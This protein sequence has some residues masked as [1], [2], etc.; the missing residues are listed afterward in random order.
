MSSMELE[1]SYNTKG[2]LQVKMWGAG[3]K[4]HN[5]TTTEKSTG[6]EQINKSLPKEIRA[7]LGESKYEIERE[8]WEKK[9][10]YKKQMD[11]KTQEIEKEK[12]N[13]EALEDSDAPQDVI[14]KSKGKNTPS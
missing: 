6:R 10:N 9:E 4:S 7:A 5:L 1:V 12:Q 13:L 11:E 14:N 8:Q 2:R 3:K